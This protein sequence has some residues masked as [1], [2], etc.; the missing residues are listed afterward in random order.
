MDIWAISAAR[1]PEQLCTRTPIARVCTQ[2][3]GASLVCTNF[4][5]LVFRQA[6]Q[7]SGHTM[8]YGL[9]GHLRA[10]L[11]RWAPS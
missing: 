5:A 6:S 2:P 7:H 1:G 9:I 3:R 10:T 8:R 4:S 11:T